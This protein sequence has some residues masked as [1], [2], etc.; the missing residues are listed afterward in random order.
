MNNRYFPAQRRYRAAF[1]PVRRADAIIDNDRWER[2][3]LARHVPDRLPRVV[4]NAL[5]AL[6]RA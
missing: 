4:E 5:S 2:P 6:V 3:R 1:D